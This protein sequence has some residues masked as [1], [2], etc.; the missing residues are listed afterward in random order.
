MAQ[1]AAQKKAEAAQNKKNLAAAIALK[2][3][4]ET[5][6][7]KIEGDQAARI[8]KNA[9]EK[10][11]SDKF[12]TDIKVEVA[13]NKRIKEDLDKASAFR[14]AGE[15]IRYEAGTTAGTR[16]PILAN[17][18]GGEYR[19]PE[20]IN[21]VFAGSTGTSYASTGGTTEVTLARDTFAN[22]MALTFGAQE[23][24]QP[25]VNE[26]YNLASGFYNTGSTIEES[27]NLSLYDAKSKGLAP[28]FT[29]RFKGVFDL[30]EKLQKGELV[31][32]PTIADFIEAEVGMGKV[33]R[34]A[35][36]GDIAT[37]EFIGDIIGKGN[38]VLDVGKLISD[39]FNVIDNAPKALRE[40]L[41]TYF[42]SVDRVSLAKALLTGTEGAAALEKKVKTV[43]VLS[44]AGS[45]GITTDFASAGDVAARGFTYE[46]ALQGYGQVKDLQRGSMLAQTQGTSFTQ[47]E[48]TGLVFAQ[49]QAAKEKA[50]RIKAA[51]IAK[52][53]G[54][55]GLAPSALRGQNTRQQV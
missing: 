42:P 32:V 49:D 9:A 1:T 43:S 5:K 17:G 53:Q 41:D 15:V 22:T 14:P 6:L 18:T 38:S 45:Q 52:F 26:I 13:L 31:T 20:E 3:K 39:T 19:A 12:L 21:P 33:L 8:A 35:G 30:Q 37:R 23:A 10:A 54:D 11:E 25:W 46:Q 40:T 47:Q 34:D 48:A 55:A 51:E 29:K 50:E 36:L 16:T 44:A 24:S 27:L 28:Q 7:A 2:S 4:L